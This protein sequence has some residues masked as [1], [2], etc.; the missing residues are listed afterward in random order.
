MNRLQVGDFERGWVDFEWRLKCQ[1]IDLGGFSQPFWRGE[2]I[3]GRRILIHAEPESGD[4]LQFIRYARLVKERGATVLVRAPK[5]LVRLLGQL[6][7]IDAMFSDDAD[8]PHFDVQVPLLSLPKI[9]GTTLTTIPTGEPYLS[10]DSDLVSRWRD[11]L[12][13]I[14]AFKVG[15]AWQGNPRSQ[16]DARRS[17]PLAH[18]A[19]LAG[20]PGMRL[21]S[22]QKGFG[23][24]QAREVRF[25]VTDLGSQLDEAAGPLMDTAAV[26]K[27][28]NLVITNDSALAHLAGGLGIPT[29]LALPFG[30]DWRW[31]LHR[32]DCPWYSTMRLFRQ[33]EAGNWEPVFDRMASILAQMLTERKAEEPIVTAMPPLPATAASLNTLGV[34]LAEK[35]RLDEA[36]ASFR[37]AL[38]LKPTLAEAHNNLGSALQTQ[39][40]SGLAAK[41]VRQAL[42]LKENYPEAWNNLGIMLVRQRRFKEAAEAFQ[43]ALQFRPGYVQA[44]CGYGLT[45]LERKKNK[46]A[47]VAFSKAIDLDPNFLVPRLHLGHALANQRQWDEADVCFREVIKRDA[48]SS[49][50]YAGLAK[51]LREQGKLDEAAQ[52]LERALELRPQ[53]FEAH[54]DLG[55]VRGRQGKHEEAMR[56]YEVAIRLRP[57]HPAAYNNLGIA[58][59]N[60][61]KRAEAVMQYRRALQLKPNYA[62]AHNNLAI[63]LT[64]EGKFDEAIGWYRRALKLR[65][66]YPEAHSNLGIALTETGKTAEAIEHFDHAIALRPDYAD[67]FMNRALSRVF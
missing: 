45:L 67:A 15:I 52:C 46:K 35:G 44:I 60:H 24:E 43:H 38:E 22:L 63:V 28:L 26:M 64:Q 53:D 17:I 40:R 47:Q 27:N 1:D 19:P 14:Q 20:V 51:V 65:S 59:A 5:P 58:Y 62:E 18:F 57:N 2:P 66:T 6:S 8:H 13:Y 31:L 61:G 9:F 39:G 10:A 32:D 4:T 42:K 48:S 34:H 7:Y 49:E 29:W 12:A 30:A 23:A 56:C 33:A 41:H 54:N 36:I 16:G 21:I 3:E 50:A 37:Q 25:S 55:I 11:Q